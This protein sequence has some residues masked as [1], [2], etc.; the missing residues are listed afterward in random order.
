MK[1]RMNKL[2]LAALAIAGAMAIPACSDEWNDHYDSAAGT[3]TTGPTILE[4]LKSS[5]ELT[6]FVAIL[7]EK[8]Y[9]K[10]LK[11]NRTYTVFAPTNS[12]LAGYSLNEKYSIVESVIKNHI[13]Y[14]LHGVNDFSDTTVT[15]LNKKVMR[16]RG[17]EF[18]ELLNPNIPVGTSNIACQNGLI[19]VLNGVAPY[20]P[21]LW[22]VIGAEAPDY[23]AFLHLQDDKVL[24]VAESTIDSIRVEDGK[25]IYLDSVVTYNNL[26]WEFGGQLNK[27]DS[28]YVALVLNDAAWQAAN[29]QLSKSFQYYPELQYT[30]WWTGTAGQAQSVKDSLTHYQENQIHHTILKSLSYRLPAIEQLLAGNHRPGYDFI[31]SVA[32]QRIPQATL[33][34]ILEGVPADSIVT[35]SNGRAYVL[36]QY[37]FK[38]Y[39]VTTTD[40]LKLEGETMNRILRL[41]NAT[42]SQTT[43]R[44]NV[45]TLSYTQNQE[46]IDKAIA[47][48]VSVYEP[49]TIDGELE[50]YKVSGQQYLTVGAGSTASAGITYGVANTYSGNYDVWI[51]FIPANVVQGIID[52]KPSDVMITT[53]Y[54][55]VA[56][57]AIS[58]NQARSG[59]FTLDPYAVMRVKVA[60]NIVLDPAWDGFLQPNDLLYTNEED[61]T[62]TDLFGKKYGLNVT[63]TNRTTLSNQ[64]TDHNLYIDSIELVPHHE[65]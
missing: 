38:N 25:T 60:D 33:R 18:G 35:A 19:H 61:I 20:I 26:Y 32:R 48:S 11:G 40:T 16:I 36:G 34:S 50:K 58:F 29:T 13:A 46:L 12:A 22:E 64:N 5:P 63:I 3:N 30:G 42:M 52:P 1:I 15:M 41:A 21:N 31:G 37:A 6:D 47:A 55:R 54:S 56:N 59:T 23:S 28:A 8:G 44:L 9:D 49:K 7:E 17:T 43:R 2:L 24:N 51:T 10:L 53:K 57:N 45:D 27:E 65:D 62:G 39:E 4:A 14:F